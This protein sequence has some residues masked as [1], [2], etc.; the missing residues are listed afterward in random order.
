MYRQESRWVKLTIERK[1]LILMALITIFGE[2]PNS[3]ISEIET[4]FELI[5]RKFIE[6]LEVPFIDY[7]YYMGLINDSLF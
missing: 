6:Y 7:D 3:D 2:I 1:K 4:D 5:E